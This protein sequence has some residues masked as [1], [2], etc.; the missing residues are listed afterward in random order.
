[1]RIVIDHV[2]KSFGKVTAL[3]DVSLEIGD[4]ELF[5]LLGPSGCGKTTLLRC[6]GGFE[7][8]T[9]GRIFFGD[10][11]VIGK[12]AHERNTAMVFQGYALW[13][14]MTVAENVAF[15]LEMRRVTKAERTRRVD[16]ALARVQISELRNRRPNELSG[17]QQQRV[18]LART[19]VVQPGCL[20]LDEPLANLDAKLRRDMRREIRSLC[21][22]SG[23]T[24]IYVTHDRQEALS[25][26]DRVAVLKDGVVR[27]VASPQEL[28]RRPASAFI[29]NFIGET[30]FLRGKVVSKET[31]RILLDVAGVRLVAESC[32]EAFGVGAEVVL[33]LRPEALFRTY[34]A[35]EGINRL[36]VTV[37]ET[38]YLGEIADHIAVSEQ[39]QEIKFF[40]LNP[41]GV[42]P[43]GEAIT[44]GVEARDVVIL[45]EAD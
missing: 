12:P 25:M 30:N 38:S 14:H 33:S 11:D 23:L 17:G 13:P 9:A 27:Q 34:E 8:P 32:P 43:R 44:L 35:G 29:A 16:E 5:F 6:L 45:P 3:S 10:E 22:E 36:Q 41:V 4:G 31:G 20:L 7:Q 39:G 18:A 24:G 15:G 28:Y 26:A 42:L 19:L 21:K 37:R 1:M 40:E 2:S